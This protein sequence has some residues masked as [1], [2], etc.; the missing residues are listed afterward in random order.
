[1]NADALTTGVENV[2]AVVASQCALEELAQR[3]SA[4]AESV[5]ET[6]R[7]RTRSRSNA[8]L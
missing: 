1:M 7:Q 8:I 5:P 6:M 3:V 4:R 2:I